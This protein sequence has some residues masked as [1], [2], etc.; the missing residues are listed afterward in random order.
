LREKIAVDKRKKK[1]S[2]DSDSDALSGWS[3]EDEIV[4]SK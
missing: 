3:D 4:E 2:S 1:N